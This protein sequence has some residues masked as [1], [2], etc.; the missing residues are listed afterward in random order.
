MEEAATDACKRCKGAPYG[1]CQRL[2]IECVFAKR[3]SHERL[4]FGEIYKSCEA[5]RATRT[6]PTSTRSACNG[7]PENPCKRCRDRG[8]HCVFI[9]YLAPSVPRSTYIELCTRQEYLML[10]CFVTGAR[11]KERELEGLASSSGDWRCKNCLESGD[12][13]CDGQDPCRCCVLKQRS[14]LYKPDL[15]I[16][17]FPKV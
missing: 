4:R 9:E 17:S 5:C 1:R 14:C 10:I 6:D 13:D 12:F 2:K 15:A 7:D 8:L 16:P 11:A 3:T